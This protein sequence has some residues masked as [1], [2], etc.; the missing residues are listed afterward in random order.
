MLK[1]LKQLKQLQALVAAA[2]PLLTTPTIN[3]FGFLNP[4]I[5]EE[6]W[7][8]ASVLALIGSALSYNLAKPFQGPRLARR[9][10]V[11]GLILALASLV[12]LL[13][14][15]TNAFSGYPAL[16]DLSA[17]IFYVLFFLGLGLAL[18][19]ASFLWIK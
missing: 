10:A 4:F 1:A 11:G 6:L 14:I 18:G 13:V 9:L 19:W 3:L 17:R 15:V 5:T 2:L 7:P 16:E 8:V 12:V